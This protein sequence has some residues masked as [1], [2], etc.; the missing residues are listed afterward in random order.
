MLPVVLVLAVLAKFAPRADTRPT[1][2][3][4][5]SFDAGQFWPALHGWLLVLA[6]VGVCVGFVAS[7]MYLVQVRRLKTKL[8]PS[9]GLK[10]FSL[11]RLEVMNRRAV[12][13]SFPLLTAGLLLGI[14]LLRHQDL[15]AWE[16][17]KILSTL[18][19]WL[20]FAILMY[21]RYAAHAGGKQL[22]LLTIVAFALTL[23]SLVSA[24]AFGPQGVR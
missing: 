18:G 14:L 3:V 16:S 7:V 21:Q 5:G 1:D 17:A 2:Q 11:E 13:W 15:A 6:A 8:P 9:R 12:L 24:H 19:L 23:F 10:L 22:A 20:V 4:W